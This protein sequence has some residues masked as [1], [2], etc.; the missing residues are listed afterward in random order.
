MTLQRDSPVFREFLFMR[1]VICG[2]SLVLIGLAGCGGGSTT[3]PDSGGGGGG[4]SENSSNSDGIKTREISSLPAVDEALRPDDQG[5][6]QY[7]LPAN[8]KTLSKNTK[9][10]KI[11]VACVPEEGSANTLPRITITAEDPPSGAP[12][13]TTESNVQE[14][15]DKLAAELKKEDKF[16][17]ESPRPLIL[18]SNAWVRHV[19]KSSF[20]E[21]PVAVQYLQT[22]QSG[23]LYTIDLTV[24]AKDNP[25]SS[26]KPIFYDKSM[27]EHRDFAYAVAA[28]M[29]F[30]KEAGGSTEPAPSAPP[31]E[32]KP[33][34]KPAE[35]AKSE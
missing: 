3:T 11:L 8:W 22:V 7:S 28:H 6:V 34:D 1:S 5:R 13:R 9:N 24:T 12:S 18:G 26:T 19:R 23:R 31:A 29:K 32:E 35:P 30:L 27:L 20:K 2:V 16:A 14:L 10:K 25:K 15:A 4:S 21:A 33:A 17:I